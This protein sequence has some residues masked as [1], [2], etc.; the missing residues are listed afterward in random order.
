M[1]YV[2]ISPAES[3]YH[4]SVSALDR[5]ALG[6][7]ESAAGKLGRAATDMDGVTQVDCA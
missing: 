2:A 5:G 4:A 7:S 1:P 6:H 3:R